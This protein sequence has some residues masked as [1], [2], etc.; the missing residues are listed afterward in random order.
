[1]VQL[2]EAWHEV[3]ILDN[4]ANSDESVLQKIEQITSKRADFIEADLRSY[5]DLER[6]FDAY[7]VDAVIHFAGLKSVWESC[8]DPF[9]YYDSNIVGTMNLLMAMDEH[10]VRKLIFSSSATVYDSTH[11]TAPFAESMRTGMTT[12]PYGTT[13]FVIEQL[14]MDMSNRK[15]MNIVSLRYFNPIGA[16]P[17][18][19]I[20][21]DPSDIPTNLLPVIMEVV[22]GTR[23]S[24][25]I[26]GTDYATP[27]GTCIRDYIHVQDLAQAHMVALEAL[28]VTETESSTRYAVYNVGT[29]KG[30][31]VQEMVQIVQ[32]VGD[33]TLDVTP[34]SRRDGDVD[35][36]VADVSKITQELWWKANMTVEQ[37]VKDTFRF[38]KQ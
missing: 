31:S 6:V 35:V 2:L 16:H 1:M 12:N 24:L 27:D 11:E 23:E 5:E 20:W 17:S 19:L 22:E 28:D 25:H 29:G 33:I 15:E 38:R 32:T 21:E 14:L 4:L 26:Y 36:A 37:A 9:W 30:T 13:K 34:V 10:D 3:V 18:G 8:K 7:D